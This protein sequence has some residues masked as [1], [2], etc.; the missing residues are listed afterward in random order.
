M[1]NISVVLK[2]SS[3]IG[4]HVKIRKKTAAENYLC[5]TKKKKQGQK[6]TS[7]V[8][9]QIYKNS[10]L[11]KKMMGFDNLSFLYTLFIQ[12]EEEAL[13]VAHSHT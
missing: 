8:Q 3:Y 5:R 6:Q 1:L 10:M 7:S 9:Y 13:F 2:T 4:T 12:E 11:F